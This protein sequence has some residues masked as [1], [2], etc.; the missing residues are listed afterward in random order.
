MTAKAM[1]GQARPLIS[2]VVPT[3]NRTDLLPE[4]IR[5]SPTE[6]G[7]WLTLAAVAIE[8]FRVSP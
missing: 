8:P 1:V 4:A 3:Y 6:P 5:L 2:V 7:A